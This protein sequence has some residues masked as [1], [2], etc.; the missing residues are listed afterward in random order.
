MNKDWKKELEE[1]DSCERLGYFQQQFLKNATKE[2]PKN[3][4]TT[5]QKQIKNEGIDDF[6]EP[7][8]PPD[9][10]ELGQSS[11]TLLHTIAA[12]YPDNPTKEKKTDVKTFLES[13]S[14]VYPCTFCA[15]DLQEVMKE[16]PPQLENQ[17]DF[18]QWMCRVRKH[19]DEVKFYST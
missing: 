12:Y 16:S 4:E 14:K 6:W 19:S 15:K 9:I 5:P 7:K 18:S 17:N 3:Q 1:C 11:W 2:K 8:N 13:F 10:I